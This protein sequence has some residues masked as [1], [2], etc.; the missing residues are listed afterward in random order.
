ME[1]ERV[2]DTC[3]STFIKVTGLSIDDKIS[4]K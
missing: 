1:D 3:R 2:V 4:E